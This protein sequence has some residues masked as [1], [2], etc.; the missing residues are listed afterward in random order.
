MASAVKKV[1]HEAFATSV[2]S[3]ASAVQGLVECVAQAAYLAAASDPSSTAGRA[4]LVDRGAFA[5]AALAIEQVS[6]S[7]RLHD[8]SSR[9]FF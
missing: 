8:W 2:A 6:W 1:E 5:R 7:F 9:R 4:G 3:V